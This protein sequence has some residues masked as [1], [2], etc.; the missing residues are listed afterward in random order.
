MD[1]GH[2]CVADRFLKAFRSEGVEGSA[3]PSF[4]EVYDRSGPKVGR[5]ADVH[6]REDGC[7]YYAP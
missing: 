6:G 2:F 4:D 3:R 7:G 1:L 5:T